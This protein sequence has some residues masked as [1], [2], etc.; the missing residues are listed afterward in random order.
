MTGRLETKMA[1][2]RKI[3]VIAEPENKPHVVLNRATW[4]AKLTDSEIE[5][6]LVDPISNPLLIGV[7]PSAESSELERAIEQVQQES[8][9]ELATIASD[10]GVVV[11]TEVVKERPIADAILKRAQDSNPAFVLKGTHYHSDAQRGIM[12]DTDWQMV[13]TCPYPLWLVKADQFEDAPVI[14]AAVDPTHEH[15]KPAELDDLIIQMAKSVAGLTHGDVHLFHSYERLSGIGDEAMKVF[16]PVKLE[17]DKIDQKIKEEHRK[18]LDSL[19]KKNAI[20][21]KHVHQLPGRTRELL[22]SFVRSHNA[23]L[24]VMGALARWGLK[25]MV[26]GS[27]A[28]RVIDH[29]PCDIVIVRQGE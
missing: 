22:P 17:I 13:R 25:R 5:L 19:A 27:T 6:L 7:I 23:Q 28:E 1:N 29:L 24:V 4:L 2:Q 14:V 15:D 9:N 3:L 16:R 21:K 18:A 26:I 12:V 20:D 11:S 10:Q 8:V